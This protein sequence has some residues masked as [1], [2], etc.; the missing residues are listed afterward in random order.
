DVGVRRP[1][2]PGS[3]AAAVVAVVAA[4][5]TVTTVVPAVVPAVVAAVVT[6]G[7]AAPPRLG[8]DDAAAVVAQGGRV[9]AVVPDVVA[10]VLEHPGPGVAADA[11][12]NVDG[13]AAGE[14]DVVEAVALARLVA[15]RPSPQV[16]R[17]AGGVGDPHPLTVHGAV[18]TGVGTRGVVLHVGD[19][20]GRPVR[21]VLGRRG[22]RRQDCRQGTDAQRGGGE[23][24]SVD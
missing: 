13:A 7:A 12:V 20:H 24:A 18:V 6:V 14:A 16:D 23:A 3:A 8:V 17:V 5:V 11:C 19:L 21:P 1:Q 4:V 22:R 2:H 9:G 15:Q 10:A